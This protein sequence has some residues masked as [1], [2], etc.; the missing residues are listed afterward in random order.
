MWLTIALIVMTLRVRQRKS[1]FPPDVGGGALV[2]AG[3][4]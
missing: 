1:F 2:C 3:D 4:L